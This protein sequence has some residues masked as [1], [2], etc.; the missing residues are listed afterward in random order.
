MLQVTETIQNLQVPPNRPDNRRVPNRIHG[1][2]GTPRVTARDLRFGEGLGA[3][4]AAG[5]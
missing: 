5:V 4:G 2:P 3:R 1:A